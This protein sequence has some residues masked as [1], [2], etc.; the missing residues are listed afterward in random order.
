MHSLPVFVRLHGRR[1]IVLGEGEGADAKRRLIERAGARPCGEEEEAT[2]AI[3]AIEDEAAAAAAVGR[4][5]ARGLL[6][7]AV[8]RPALC[9]F[10][11]PAIVDRDPV[12]VAIGTGG[13]SAGLA[14]ALRQRLEVMLPQ[15]LGSLAE[16]LH[17]ARTA[18]RDRWPRPDDR[19]RAIDRA[20][21]PA[22]PLDP[23][24]ATDP[25]AVGRWAQ[26]GEGA[27]DGP[28]LR[29]IALHSP[30][31]DDLTLRQARLL[32]G[33]DRIFHRRTIPAAILAR[34][35]ADAARIACD[36]VPDEIG[37]GLSVDLGWSAR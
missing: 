12:L 5:R 20:L 25:G 9:D 19:R 22:G 36:A 34:A 11:L 26:N 27:A 4:L 1:V 8:D 37:P 31:P 35:R 2:L 21:E 16:A 3:V 24:G 18:I 33:A 14:K 17:A 29:L 6:V 13:A 30:D 28:A 7:N 10:T 23:L 32:A 15:S